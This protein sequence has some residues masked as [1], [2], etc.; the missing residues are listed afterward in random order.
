MGRVQGGIA[1]AKGASM[2]RFPHVAIALLLGAVPAEFSLA[3]SVGETGVK[4]VERYYPRKS[5]ERGEQGIAVFLLE[6]DS[7]A[8][9]KSCLIV[10]SSG[11]P[12][13]DTATCDLV[14]VHAKFAPS[15][16]D[17]SG[18]ATRMGFVAWNLP[19]AYA[20]N[21]RKA[22][23]KTVMSKAALEAAKIICERSSVAG[24]MIKT[25]TLC[26]SRSDWVIARAEARDKKDRF[27]NPMYDRQHGCHYVST[28]C[29]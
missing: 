12:R 23:A 24:S 16:N 15:A 4:L 27:A 22:P 28:K 19:P 2:T 5:L 17:K 1:L 18:A 6:L 7:N 8:K 10:E 14:V 3:T 13:L 25:T 29:N 26:L 21:A 9:I 20:A 11:Y